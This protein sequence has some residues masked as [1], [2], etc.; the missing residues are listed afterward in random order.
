[1]RYVLRLLIERLNLRRVACGERLTRLKLASKRSV[2]LINQHEL[3]CSSNLTSGLFLRSILIIS[4]LCT[5]APIKLYAAPERARFE[6][7]VVNVIDGD[8][9]VVKVNQ[10][11]E[12]LRLIGID[13]PESRPNKRA[14]K[15]AERRNLDRTAILKLGNQASN[16]A[17]GLL[18]KRS[19]VFIE[20]DVERRDH[21]GRLL[22]YMWLP[23]GKMFNEEIL[24]AGFAYLLTVP[25][26]VRYSNKLSDALREGRS[27]KR[28]L[29]GRN[30]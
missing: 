21:Y 15:Q 6:A 23:D 9:V 17:R 14:D 3:S 28:G 7:T 5:L 8:T 2:A 22:G 4:A 10:R 27:K 1:M 26:N 30:D 19:T 25:P 11:N 29:W 13:T 24:K 12:H 16:Y 20:F 18:P